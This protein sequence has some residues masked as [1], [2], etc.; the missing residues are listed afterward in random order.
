MTDFESAART[1]T[2][3]LAALGVGHALVGGFAVSIRCEPRFTRD[4]DL[5]VAVEG[6]DAAEAVVNAL[7]QDGDEVLGTV[8][9]DAV[10]RLATVRLALGGGDD[11]VDLLFASSGIEPEIAAGAERIEA[12]PGLVLPVA[13]IGHLIALKILSSDAQSR[14]QDAL[15]LRALIDVAEEADLEAARAAVNLIEARGYQRGRD[16]AAALAALVDSR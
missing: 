12:L 2:N 16:L 1:T 10:G 7:V 14:P 15:D 3:R 4:I 13:T 9:Q 11:V 5:V 8:E 6:D